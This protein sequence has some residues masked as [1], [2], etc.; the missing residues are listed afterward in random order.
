MIGGANHP[1]PSPAHLELQFIERMES[2]HGE[3]DD[4]A[5]HYVS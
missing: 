5:V 4:L 1:L 2:L 3:C